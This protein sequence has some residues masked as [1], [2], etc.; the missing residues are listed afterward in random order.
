M[1]MAVCCPG[2]F[3]CHLPVLGAHPQAAAE[4]VAARPPAG[5]RGLG[6]VVALGKDVDFRA[7]PAPAVL[8]YIRVNL[9]PARLG[10]ALFTP[11]SYPSYYSQQF[12]NQCKLHC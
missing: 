9:M 5:G 12:E 8:T 6:L 3:I 11:S 7:L 1:L 10:R 4:A 2:H